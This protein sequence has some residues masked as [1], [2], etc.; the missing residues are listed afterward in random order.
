MKKLSRIIS[1]TTLSLLLPAFPATINVAHAVD[2]TKVSST[3]IGDGSNSTIAGRTYYVDSITSTSV[4]TWSVPSRVSYADILIVGGGGGGGGGAGYFAAGNGGGGGGGAG[5]VRMSNAV[6]L[7]GF[8]LLTVQ[9]GAGGAGGAGGS[10]GVAGV[11]GSSGEASSI[12]ELSLAAAGGSGGSRGVSANGGAGGSSGAG[13]TGGTGGSSSLWVGGSG[14]SSTLNGVNASMS[15]VTG[16][17]AFFSSLSVADSFSFGGGGSA[18]NAWGSRS[19]TYGS[20]GHGGRGALYNGCG[21][22]NSTYNYGY[23]AVAGT[24]GVVLIRYWLEP[25]EEEIAAQVEAARAVSLATARAAQALREAEKLALRLEISNKFKSAEKV[26]IE[27]FKQAEIAGVTSENID[28]VSAEILALPESSRADITQI[29]KIA[30]KYEVVGK[31]ASDQ[32]SNIYPAD[33]IKIGLIPEDSKHK[34]L[35][36]LALKKLPSTER[37]SFVAIKTVL[38]AE[39]ERIQAKKLRLAAALARRTL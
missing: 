35:L 23:S 19:V 9:V 26:S 2:C 1:I 38:D 34:T 25:T 4:C 30:L 17:S 36:T 32:I 18:C 29:L 13:F 5:Q 8:S 14:A 11:T 27:T 33:L 20:G 22:T 37:S 12:T 16:T 31:L 7:N 24:Q 15:A 21:S 39:M 6:A 10:T 3:F 28:D